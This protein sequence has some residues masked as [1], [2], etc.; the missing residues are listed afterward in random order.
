M[1]YSSFITL[2]ASLII[3]VLCVRFALRREYQSIG[4]ISLYFLF[5]IFLLIYKAAFLEFYF[6]KWLLYTAI[7]IG[8]T[9]FLIINRK[10][11]FGFPSG[12]K[13]PV[14]FAFLFILSSI[15]SGVLSLNRREA[16]TR[17]LTFSLV[18]LLAF[19]ISRQD[20]LRGVKYFFMSL[21]VFDLVL[22]G[23]SAMGIFSDDFYTASGRFGGL[24]HMPTEIVIYAYT[25]IAVTLT[26][27]LTS[28]KYGFFYVIALMI[29]LAQIMLAQSRSG[30][31]CTIIILFG[32][33]IILRKRKV[34]FVLSSMTVISLLYIL[35]ANISMEKI[36]F[37]VLRGESIEEIYGI[38]KTYAEN[39]I[40]AFRESPYFGIG[41]G[42]IPYWFTPLTME[43][44]PFE[45][46]I[47]R[48]ANQA[49]YHLILA[50]TGAIGLSLYLLWLF[51]TLVIGLKKIAS[52]RNAGD[53]NYTYLGALF[54]IFVAYSVNGIFEGFP[55][56]AGSVV[57]I[58]QWIISGLFLFYPSYRPIKFVQVG[59]LRRLSTGF[60]WHIKKEDRF[61]G[62]APEKRKD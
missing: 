21:F 25:L 19:F 35:S 14:I 42:S 36:V 40:L 1:E 30:Y 45:S 57:A 62:Q 32:I 15:I 53:R 54:V 7:V 43:G 13:W 47:Q 44:M 28:K 59:H 39:A 20:T 61:H 58:R 33:V 12:Q 11:S 26:L 6:T 48:V 55:A 17:A 51:T 37:T 46:S 60:H 24:M 3:L 16:A 5:S 8:W 38:R 9:F 2:L 23:T 4:F 49:G 52:A 18:F 29:S 27:Q 56:S 41:M 34:F 50:E 10:I 31:L 22:V